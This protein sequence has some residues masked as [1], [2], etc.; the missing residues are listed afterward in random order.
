VGADGQLHRLLLT[1]P[2]I[3]KHIVVH[4]PRDTRYM[5][6]DWTT[7]DYAYNAVQVTFLPRKE[8]LTRN[9]ELVDASSVLFACPKGTHE[10]LRSGTWATVRYALKQHKEVVVI[11]PDG[12]IQTRR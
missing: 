7:D 1:Y 2:D 5:Y 3:T 10:E 6:Q 4:Q 8:Y 11:Y 12:S 9:H